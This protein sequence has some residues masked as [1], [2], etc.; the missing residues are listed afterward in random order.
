MLRTSGFASG[1]G[2]GGGGVGGLC[3][4]GSLVV[5][6]GRKTS[7]SK[8]RVSS[9]VEDD[10]GSGGVVDRKRR[11]GADGIT[12]EAG[13]GGRRDSGEGGGRTK[14]VG[15]SEAGTVEGITS[16]SKDASTRLLVKRLGREPEASRFAD[17][18]V[19]DLLNFDGDFWASFALRV[20]RGERRDGPGCGAGGCAVAGA[21]FARAGA[22]AVESDSTLLRLGPP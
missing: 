5:G 3:C 20:L 1:N 8:V 18:D 16:V 4:C 7:S 21:G 10:G 9:T 19:D 6:T 13:C 22:G 14:E 12:R 11:G 2:L 17:A 15:R